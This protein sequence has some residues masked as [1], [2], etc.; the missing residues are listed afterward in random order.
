MSSH[1]SECKPLADG[2]TPG[3]A[4]AYPGDEILYVRGQQA[5]LVYS[6]AGAVF[7]PSLD[8][9]TG[10]GAFLVTSFGFTVEDA[11]TAGKLLSEELVK[12]GSGRWGLGFGVEGLG[13]ILSAT[14][15]DAF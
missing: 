7:D 15:S 12:V 10:V 8:D 14:S 5:V 6:S 3:A 1:V 11:A 2:V 13:L 4:V 9:P